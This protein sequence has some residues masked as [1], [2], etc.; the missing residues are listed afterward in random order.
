VY[1]ALSSTTWPDLSHFAT[2]GSITT[3]RVVVFQV[4]F[5]FFRSSYLFLPEEIYLT[6]NHIAN[7]KGSS[8]GSLYQQEICDEPTSKNLHVS[9]LIATEHVL[10]MSILTMRVIYKSPHSSEG[11]L[12]VWITNFHRFF[13]KPIPAL[14]FFLWF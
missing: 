8:V 11:Y 3:A 2:T 14:L 5:L 12:E 7:V 1:I 9:S 10:I 13:Q 4:L 6:S